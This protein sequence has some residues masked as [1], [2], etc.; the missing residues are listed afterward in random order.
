MQALLVRVGIDCTDGGNWNGPVDSKSGDFVY[1]PIAETKSLRDGFERFYD[2]LQP[3]LMLVWGRTRLA[4][5]FAA[6][7]TRPD[8]GLRKSSISKHR[9][10][11][12]IKRVLREE[13]GIFRDVV[14]I[15][16]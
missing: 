7:P 8:L 16:E 11:F 1:V 2:E 6:L 12:Q 3:A 10:P 14:A 15:R 13:N 5:A 9:S 4:E